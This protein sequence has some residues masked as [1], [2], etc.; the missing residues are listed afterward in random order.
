MRISFSFGRCSITNHLLQIGQLPLTSPHFGW[1]PIIMADCYVKWERD[2]S[3]HRALYV[4]SLAETL[5]STDWAREFETPRESLA[6]P[7]DSAS[8]TRSEICISGELF[9]WPIVLAFA[10]YV[11]SR[12]FSPALRLCS[13][14]RVYPRFAFEVYL[15]NITQAEVDN[16]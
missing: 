3:L 8:V 16:G 9:I 2:L 11:F 6:S 15:F 13:C 4:E 5:L 14:P 7:W 1:Y 12:F 10:A